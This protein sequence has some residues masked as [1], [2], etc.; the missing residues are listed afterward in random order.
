VKGGAPP[1]PVSLKLEV[2][3]VTPKPRS[4]VGLH[5]LPEGVRLV[6]HVPYRLS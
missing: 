5:S 1:G 6:T 4:L 2:K 3:E